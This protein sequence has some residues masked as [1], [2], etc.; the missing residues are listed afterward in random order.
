MIS[1]AQETATPG[2]FKYKVNLRARRGAVKTRLGSRRSDGQKVFYHKTLPACT[3]YGMTCKGIMIRNAEQGMY[4]AT[5]AHINF[6]GF[7][8]ALSY[9]DMERPQSAHKQK[10]S[11]QIYI[12]CNSRSANRKSGGKF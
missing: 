1:I 11:Q 8:E 5:V 12:S 4:D 6:R 7:H 2:E 9:I 3:D 10:V